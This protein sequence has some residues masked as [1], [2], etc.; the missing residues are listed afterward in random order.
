M[1]I[2]LPLDLDCYNKHQQCDNNEATLF[3]NFPF[4]LD[5]I[6]LTFTVLIYLYLYFKHPTFCF[7]NLFSCKSP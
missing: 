7:N 5:C 2:S 6:V 3:I 1:Y 4:F